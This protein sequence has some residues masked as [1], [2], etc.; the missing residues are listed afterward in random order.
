MAYAFLHLDTIGPD[1]FGNYFARYFAE[2]AY[3]S[4]TLLNLIG[5]LFLFLDMSSL[6]ELILSD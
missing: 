4:T 1:L 2:L 6:Y 5:L 3:S